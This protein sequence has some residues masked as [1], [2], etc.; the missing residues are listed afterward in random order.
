M[1]RYAVLA[2]VAAAVLAAPA[3]AQDS[4]QGTAPAP[5]E[6]KVCK[7]IVPTGSVMAVVTCRTRAEWDAIASKSRADIERTRDIERAKSQV[8]V[9]H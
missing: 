1:H 5:A 9:Q 8:G 4:T 2:A 6:K 3:M 7:R